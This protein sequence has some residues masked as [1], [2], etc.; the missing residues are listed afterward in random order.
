MPHPGPLGALSVSLSR[1]LATA[2]DLIT[3]RLA[4]IGTEFEL[5]A[6]RLFDGLLWGSVALMLMG[7]GIAFLSG[8]V[9]MLCWDN[10]RLTSVAALAACYLGAGALLLRKA[11]AQLVSVTGVFGL[12]IGELQQDSKSMSKENG[13]G[14]P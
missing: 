9:M 13:H 7:F 14:L 10:Y 6:H 2:L 1:L 3:V 5:A 11:R 8:L 12:S 4:L